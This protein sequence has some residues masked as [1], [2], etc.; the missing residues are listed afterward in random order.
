M[1]NVRVRF[2]A[3]ESASEA[4]LSVLESRLGWEL[5]A[6]LRS[7]ANELGDA[8]VCGALD[9]NDRYSILSFLDLRQIAAADDWLAEEYIEAGIL[10]FARC[11]LGGL[12][13]L[14][15]DG[16]VRFRLVYSGETILET[17]AESYDE[18]ERRIVVQD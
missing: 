9:G 15:K 1:N 6:D 11:E 7:L 17:V 2:E 12:Y 3:G 10:P 16:K 8:F 18:F 5:P 14:E 4:E 13:L